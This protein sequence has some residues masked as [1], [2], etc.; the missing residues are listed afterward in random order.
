MVEKV[1]SLS[2]NLVAF[3]SVIF[4]RPVSMLLWRSFVISTNANIQSAKL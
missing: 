3:F 2:P 1:N 4:G